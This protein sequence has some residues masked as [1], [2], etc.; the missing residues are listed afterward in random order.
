MKFFFRRNE[1]V[2]LE[3]AI[4]YY[5]QALEAHDPG[6]RGPER[7]DIFITLGSC[8]KLIFDHTGLIDDLEEATHLLRM[9]LSLLPAQDPRLPFIL[10]LLSLCSS[11]L[12]QREE[13]IKD[14]NESIQQIRGA[15]DLYNPE[16]LR[17]SGS[18]NCLSRYLVTRHIE[19]GRGIQDLDDAI[20]YA[21]E[22]IPNYPVGH[23]DKSH[24]LLNLSMCLHMWHTQRGGW[25]EREKAIQHL[26]EFLSAY[27]SASPE[28]RIALV[29]LGNCL[30]SRLDQ[31]PIVQYLEDAIL[32]YR[33]TLSILPSDSSYQDWGGV[34]VNLS[35]ALLMKYEFQNSIPDLDEATWSVHKAL[36]FCSAKDRP[37]LLSHLANCLKARYKHCGDV[38]CLRSAIQ[39]YRQA[40]S[41]HPQGHRSNLYTLRNLSGCL[42]LQYYHSGAMQDLKE[43]VESI[44]KVINHF[45][46]MNP[47]QS[48]ALAHLASMYA[49]NTEVLAPFYDVTVVSTLFEKASSLP[50]A[51][52]RDRL[53]ASRRWT[54]EV[55]GPSRL[56]A[57][58]Q[59]LKLVDQQLLLRSSIT[60]R[61]QLLQTIPDDL[62]L[63]AVATAIEC[64][65]TKTA[66]ELLEQG[67]TLLWSQMNRYRT[68]IDRL[69]ETQ[70]SSRI[71]KAQSAIRK[72]CNLWNPEE[73][74]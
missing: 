9:G 8:L 55:P 62:A 14:L 70:A 47:N 40:L 26:R 24:P 2:H 72:L 53:S 33:E 59:L 16:E 4:S 67:R 15:S 51:S 13:K 61:H 19:E 69:R 38:E 23:P 46:P 7:V 18:A 17:R 60:S 30:I 6:V 65:E 48:S 37:G 36:S 45:E 52:F 5:R 63:D 41:L 71:H 1:V 31:E 44:H 12:Y 50:T 39:Y 28:R 27:P 32:C 56:S 64:G 11:S 20:R 73:F 57:Y 34:L 10:N 21:R 68:P 49:K 35:D 54:Q 3:E 42:E 29:T 25:E 66:V 74:R 58:Q 22:S 43:A